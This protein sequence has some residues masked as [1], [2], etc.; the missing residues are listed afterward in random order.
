MI[1]AIT[2]K[3]MILGDSGVGKSQMFSRLV[4]KT[5]DENSLPTAGIDFA[6][7]VM[8]ISSGEM[9]KAQIVDT[10]GLDRFR[11]IIQSY[12]TL[13][14][15]AL[16]VY[17]ITN[18][19]TFDSVRRWVTGFRE[20]C[21]KDFVP[22]I[23]VVGNKAERES[24]AYREVE[25]SEAK[26]YAVAQGFFFMEVS[27]MENE[28][29]DLAFSILLTD[30]YHTMH[31]IHKLSAVPTIAAVPVP[32]SRAASP[33]TQ[34]TPATTT[35]VQDDVAAV[36]TTS[37]S[38]SLASS[39][40]AVPP[41]SDAG[42]LRRASTVSAA[43]SSY[44]WPFATSANP[45]AATSPLHS[46]P[47]SAAPSSA[48][49]P[50][51]S[52][53]A[54]VDG[55]TRAQQALA[56]AMRQHKPIT[57]DDD[58]DEEDGP[59]SPVQL[60]RRAT[61]AGPPTA[62]T[63]ASTGSFFY[64]IARTLIG[65]GGAAEETEEEEDDEDLAGSSPSGYL[66]RGSSQSATL[67]RNGMLIPPPRRES[68]AATVLET[69][70]IPLPVPGSQAAANNSAPT[71]P[72]VHQQRAALRRAQ[73]VAAAAGRFAVRGSS[74]SPQPRS[75]PGGY[76]GVAEDGARSPTSDS[77]VALSSSSTTPTG[78]AMLQMEPVY[79]EADDAA[80]PLPP[81]QPVFRQR[82]V[83]VVEEEDDEEAVD[84]AV[85]MP[86]VPASR[87]PAKPAADGARLLPPRPQ[88]VRASSLV[89]TTSNPFDIDPLPVP[90]PP[91]AT[92]A[93]AT[94]AAR[95]FLD[96]ETALLKL[97]ATAASHAG[98]PRKFEM[99]LASLGGGLVD[100]RVS[101]VAAAAD[102]GE[103]GARRAARVKNTAPLVPLGPLPAFLTTPST[104]KAS[105]VVPD[106]PAPVAPPRSSRPPPPRVDVSA[107]APNLAQEDAVPLPPP[108]ST[109]A[110]VA[111]KTEAEAEEEEAADA[112]GGLPDAAFPYPVY[113][114][115]ADL[116]RRNTV[117]GMMRKKRGARLR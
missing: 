109:S 24:E 29:V 102:V 61:T 58:S 45:S 39:T 68:V 66:G 94:P 14:S 70:V 81:G 4:K 44:F 2:V 100:D 112:V 16:V 110:R 34:S 55:A 103:K 26:A 57:M 115:G 23:M 10:S 91:P 50:T 75:A 82:L 73:T 32:P 21:K 72:Y 90:V 69:G 52:Q 87:G 13:A 15:G 95:S 11:S 41:A 78:W 62:S 85:Q 18:R 43:S 31:N 116:A 117:A 97:D 96:N 42:G 25:A 47:L 40:T 79:D 104:P 80:P 99:D 5:F 63:D 107:S 64:G 6:T 77:A 60:A 37:T 114:G 101:T 48:T 1:N 17:D 89:V 35:A 30:V 36:S 98:L 33:Q 9:V 3:I 54:A 20:K 22:P 53:P 12:W 7:H 106:A 51:L 84:A 49:S 113:G 8:K 46:R 67:A 108:R 74:A 83:G 56:E 71:N 27:A 92:A 105:P 93:P 111:S 19:E 59:T 88:P 65:G 76:D 38:S 86:P 28:N